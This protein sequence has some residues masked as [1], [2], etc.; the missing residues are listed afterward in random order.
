MLKTE[1][2]QSAESAR[3]LAGARYHAR[4]QKRVELDAATCEHWPRCVELDFLQLD[5]LP[6]RSPM[7]VLNKCAE[8]G[9]PLITQRH[10]GKKFGYKLGPV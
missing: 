2:G 4:R 10:V 1:D 5:K 6:V 8:F 7:Y 9:Q 3:R